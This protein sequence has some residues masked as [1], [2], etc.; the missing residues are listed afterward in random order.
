M[1]MPLFFRLL[2][3]YLIWFYRITGYALVDFVTGTLVLAL[4]AVI[5]GELSISL[6]FLATRKH[7]DQVTDEVVRY[8]NLSV[9]ALAARDKRAY[10]AANQLANDAFGKS[11][12]MQIALSAAFLWP[13]P[14]ALA[15]MQYRFME[16]EFPLPIIPY[17]L[18]YIGVFLSLY[19]G[20]Y[21]VFKPVKDKIPYFRRIKEIL[22]ASSHSAQK[23]K[24]FGDLLL[25][26]TP[27]NPEGGE[28]S[29]PP[30]KLTR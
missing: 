4:L 16:V 20:A 14:F 27:G 1:E 26:P 29:S 24:S 15:W 17:A 5:I 28:I 2:D 13:I 7:T 25:R 11:F 12:F 10:T 30:S 21:F 3:P 23:L 9:D 19:V 22:D 8:Q 18:G 6:A